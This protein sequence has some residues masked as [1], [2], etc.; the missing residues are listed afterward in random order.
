[1]ELP[2]SMPCKDLC[3]VHPEY[4]AGRMQQHEDFYRGGDQF[5]ANK[6]KYLRRRA[7]ES[8]PGGDAWR[9]ARLACAYYT[10]HVGGIIDQ[11]VAASTQ[12]APVIHTNGNGDN[13]NDYWYRLARNADGRGR[14]LATIVRVLL[15]SMF[16]HKRGY[17]AID[18]PKPN[19]QASPYTLADQKRLGELDAR[20]C[21]IEPREV[22]D[23]EHDE[24]GCLAWVKTHSV[25]MA[26][27][28]EYGPR[29][30]E[31]HTWTIYTADTVSEYVA[32]CKPKTVF[33]DKDFATCISSQ[34]HRLNAVPIITVEAP[35]GLWVM[36]RLMSTAMAFFNREA[37]REFALDTG[38]LSVP[39]IKTSRGDLSNLVMSEMAAI[40]LEVDDSFEF[41]SPNVGIF[42]A[43]KDDC[44][45]LLQN[46]YSAIQA[47]AWR[48][49]AQQEN[50]RQSGVAKYRDNAPLEVLLGAFAA[51]LIDALE[52]AVALIAN[53]RSEQDLT[54]WVG[55]L[56]SFDVQATELEI[57]RT[58]AFCA[59]I[60]DTLP[61]AAKE[62]KKRLALSYL[63]DATPDVLKAI[64][65]ESNAKPKEEIQPEG[66]A[67]TE[68]KAEEVKE[69]SAVR[70]SYAGNEVAG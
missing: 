21:A 70:Q 54:P 40:K 65:E 42:Q 49:A 25:D 24:T 52:R 50:A 20:L 31:R 51:P 6:E 38:A 32:E 19:E 67:E 53:M 29:D 27:S 43:L 62:A 12:A 26:R 46:L 55:G 16:V 69:V 13:R 8:T 41:A 60:G 48:A 18:F 7:I 15:T 33:T 68:G 56:D 5:E 44:D 36:D 58:Q 59:V 61:S 11:L 1:M 34:S 17:L 37:S 39:V 10:P 4:N 45:Y 30:K 14:D 23:W 57:N 2:Q 9:K 47:L 22:T 3:A 28:T 35:H 66:K 63:S 64:N